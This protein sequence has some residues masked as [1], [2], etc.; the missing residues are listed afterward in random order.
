MIKTINFIGL[1]LI[2]FALIGVY[3]YYGFKLSIFLCM[4]FLGSR[5][6]RVGKYFLK[7]G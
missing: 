3:Q 4:I 7:R 2:S 5:M 6:E 1:L